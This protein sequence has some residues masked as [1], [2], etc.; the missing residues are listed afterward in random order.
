ML[1]QNGQASTFGVTIYFAADGTYID[2]FLQNSTSVL[3]MSLFLK[4]NRCSWFPM[5]LDIAGYPRLFFFSCSP[6]L[7]LVPVGVK[8]NTSSVL[9]PSHD[10]ADRSFGHHHLELPGKIQKY[11]DV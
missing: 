11:A 1:L 4:V 8:T 9:H 3:L 7:E 2:Y 5:L 10:V 6:L